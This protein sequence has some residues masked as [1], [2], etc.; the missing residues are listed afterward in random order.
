MR[1]M[2]LR[3]W[4]VGVAVLGMALSVGLTGAAP[5]ATPAAQTEMMP[6]QAVFERNCAVCHGTRASGR[7]GPPLNML[8]PQLAELPPEVIAESLTEL[9]RGGIP[10]AMPMF[11]P[12]QLSDAEILDLTNY[13]IAQNNTVPAPS[14]Y[15]ALEPVT[16]E[17]AAGR[18]YFSQTGHSVGGEFLT[19]WRR[20]GGL[21]VFGLPLSEEYNG[22]SPEN[23][24][25]Y[26]M[27]LFERARMELHPNN[28][29]GQRVQLALLGA[30]ELRLRT[31][32]LMG[33]EGDGGGPPPEA[34]QQRGAWLRQ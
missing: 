10:G 4:V 19:F 31:H 1:R 16:A 17:E 22:M 11:V 34:M 25:V 33:R 15:D 30:E 29:P 20:Y 21:R 6:G 27:Q 9:V 2:T 5:A 18:A 32:F 14:L 24:Q 12:E 26:R 8:P 28:P 13:L 7:M 3:P 23:G